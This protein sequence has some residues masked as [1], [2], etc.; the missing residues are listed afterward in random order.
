M[1]SARYDHSA[2]PSS[3][4]DEND[5]AEFRTRLCHRIQYRG[6]C[7]YG[8]NWIYAHSESELRLVEDPIPSCAIKIY[9][10]IECFKNSHKSITGSNVSPVRYNYESWTRNNTFNQNEQ[11]PVLSYCKT[12]AEKEAHI[13]DLNYSVGKLHNTIENLESE[14]KHL[15]QANQ[16]LRSKNTRQLPRQNPLKAT[17]NNYEQL[18]S[19]ISCHPENIFSDFDAL[20][21]CS[22]CWT[23]MQSPVI[24]KSGNTVCEGCFKTLK[25]DP[26]D[27]TKR[28]NEKIKN[29]FCLN[30]IG[31]LDSVQ[32]RYY[33]MKIE[34]SEGI[35]RDHDED[36]EWESRGYNNQFE[37][38][39][40]NTE[41]MRLNS[42][43]QYKFN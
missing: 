29:I 27:S 15:K 39:S 35:K 24:L 2:N 16:S 40:L 18:L 5:I 32:S 22:I 26:F 10:D 13:N 33:N 41:S 36:R 4:C 1:Y 11:D 28:C 3:F 6:T 42:A 17:Q 12:L 37:R 7:K 20:L 34:Q 23:K 25:R 30:V 19:K 14:V 21:E 9:E 31:V 43:T 8:R 38:E